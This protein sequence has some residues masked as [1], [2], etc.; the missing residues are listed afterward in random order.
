MGQ[1]RDELHLCT[2]SWCEVQGVLSFEKLAND[3][4]NEIH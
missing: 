1:G 2:R 3:W 4:G